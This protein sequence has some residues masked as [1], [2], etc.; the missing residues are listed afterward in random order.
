LLDVLQSP[1]RDELRVRRLFLLPAVAL[2]AGLRLFLFLSFPLVGILLDSEF[3]IF[4]SYFPVWA[5]IISFVSLQGKKVPNIWPEDGMVCLW[6]PLLSL[7]CQI[8]FPTR[9]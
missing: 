6:D 9:G 2:Q 3:L 5:I 4:N 7:T 1:L 8:T